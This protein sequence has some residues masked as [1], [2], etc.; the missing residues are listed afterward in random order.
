[1]IC[2]LRFSGS[3]LFLASLLLLLSTG[4]SLGEQRSISEERLLREFIS[5][6]FSS[7]S[8]PDIEAYSKCFHPQASIHCIDR[9]GNPHLSL[10]DTF[11]SEQRQAQ[12]SASEPM[13]EKPTQSS[14]KVRGR[15]AHAMVRWELHKG[16]ASYT[17]TDYFTFLKTHTGWRI[18]SLIFE[19]DEK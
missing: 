11:I 6:Y 16:G 10:L 5:D 9:S 12:L 14:I 15:I 13:I 1:M 3:L 17:G 18:L 4:S 2:F 19:Q 7:W 8:K